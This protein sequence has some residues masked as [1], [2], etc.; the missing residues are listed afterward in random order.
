MEDLIAEH[1]VA[2]WLVVYVIRLAIVLYGPDKYKFLMR[3]LTASGSLDQRLS[4][5][6]KFALEG[7]ERDCGQC[8][9]WSR[10]SETKSRWKEGVEK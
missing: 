7:I 2:D 4:Q 3:G 9:G 10:A 6:S 1:Y 5:C 8:I